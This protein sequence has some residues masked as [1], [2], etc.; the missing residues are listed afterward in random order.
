MDERSLAEAHAPIVAGA[1]GLPNGG[2]SI[3][4]T[5]IGLAQSSMPRRALFAR[6]PFLGAAFLGACSN[7]VSSHDEAG[8]YGDERSGEIVIDSFND[9][10]GGFSFVAKAVASVPGR[11][12]LKVSRLYY[13]LVQPGQEATPWSMLV[14]AGHRPVAEYTSL[15]WMVTEIRGTSGNWC[16]LVGNR[17]PGTSNLST[18]SRLGSYPISGNNDL[19]GLLTR[20]RRGTIGLGFSA[21]DGTVLPDGQSAFD[22]LAPVTSPERGAPYYVAWLLTQGFNRDR[23]RSM[24]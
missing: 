6:V 12:A 14:D 2:A 17:W 22:I 7:P 18:V 4:D 10:D 5:M 24:A 1:N 9:A 19:N 20:F 8:L 23:A 11:Y 13:F 3:G 21:D 15:G 16:C